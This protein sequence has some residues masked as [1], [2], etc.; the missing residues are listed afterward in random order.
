MAAS[1]SWSL[2]DRWPQMTY[3]PRALRLIWDAAGGWMAVWAA[4]LIV[5]GLLPVVTVYLTK[6]LV[7]AV[8]TAMGAGLS[9]AAVE[10]VL[11]PAVLMGAV[12][13]AQELLGGL[14]QW[15]RV[16][17]SELVEDH[18]KKLIHDK[19][20]ALDFSFYESSDYY[21][22]MERARREGSGRSLTLVQS[23]GGIGKN[24]ITLLGV[25]GLLVRYGTWW[26]PVAL[27]ASTLPALYV[28]FKYN[29]RE[30][31]WNERT[32]PDRRW[33]SYYDLLLTSD[34]SAAE[35]R[36][37]QQGG[38]YRARY[39]DL[40]AR[41]RGERLDIVRDQNIARIGARGLAL[42]VT[43]AIMAWMVARV[44]RGLATLGD[45]ALFYQAFNQGQ[46][47]MRSLLSGVGQIHASAIFLEH[48]FTYLELEPAVTVPEHPHPA[49]ERLRTGIR[50]E[51][52]SFRYPEA[53]RLALKNFSLDLPAGATV[54]L[55]GPNGAGKSTLI[56]LLCRLY[57]VEG[58]RVTIDG[59]DVR[60]MDPDALR[61]RITVMFQRPGHYQASVAEN[62]SMEHAR[63]EDG[64]ARLE[65]AARSG[66]AHEIIKGLRDGY[67]TRLGKWFPGGTELSGGQWQRI[68]LARA[69]YRDAPIV[70]LDEPTSF[71]DS[72]AENE[73]MRRFCRMV[74]DQT[75]LLVT[76]RFTT[77]MRADIIHV[78][79]DG[80]IIES[81]T[82]D[83][84]V[85]LGGRYAESWRAQVQSS[86]RP[87]PPQ[88]NG[89]DAPR[90]SARLSRD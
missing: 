48:L 75:A 88:G 59:T 76:H 11:V 86:D 22:R 66:G 89:A 73:W 46:G 84:L 87:A 79:D 10:T 49:P 14:D 16:A 65:E 82:H 55:V 44:M 34:W 30:H 64:G 67:D 60:Q 69:F 63:A 38:R 74:E 6:V 78:M 52:V 68:T 7:D 71:M 19:A 81:G 83:E 33:A 41:L 21:D 12:L 25:G 15:V 62:I 58:G 20:A 61:R 28:V 29:R 85:A 39:Q 9:W 13:V 36:M 31:E 37:Y 23:I 24:T 80:R 70:A 77:A 45:V 27:V 32:T 50:F 42:V 57:D 8:D 18:V 17:Q 47:L 51:N 5:Q 54:A 26:V 3:I 4:L 90:A 2:R 1:P 56:K 43:A 72:W 35:I 40:R 53:D